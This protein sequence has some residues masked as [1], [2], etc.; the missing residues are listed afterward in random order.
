MA[1]I[2]MSNPSVRIFHRKDEVQA[3]MHPDVQKKTPHFHNQCELIL[4]VGG[5]ADFNISGT[6]YHLEPGH[7]LVINNLENH[8]ILSHSEGYDRYTAR[9]SNEILASM[10]HDPLLLSI[11]KQRI[12]GF[13]HQYICTPQE[14]VRYTRLLDIMVHEYQLQRPYWEQLILSKL[15][16]ILI[17]MYRTQPNA[18]PG[19]RQ[20]NGQGLI[21]NIQNYIESHLDEDLR[22]ETVANKFFISKYHLSHSFREITGYGYK[23]YVITARLSKAKDLLLRSSEEIQKIG[24]SVGFNSTSHF[25]RSFKSMEGI[26]P[27]QYRNQGK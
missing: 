6:V 1:E 18:F 19:T 16:D 5:Y 17:Y 8:S 10:V 13:C 21:Y 15:T 25:I 14:T 11:F 27:L 23:E 24:S 9:F 2:D 4:N 12:P 22:L 20:A 7:I 26:S 3:Y